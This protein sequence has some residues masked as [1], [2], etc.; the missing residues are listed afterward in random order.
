M[1]TQL[2]AAQPAE[3]QQGE[4]AR[5]Q[6]GAGGGMEA[7]PQQQQQQQ[8]QQQRYSLFCKSPNNESGLLVG[9]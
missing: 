6:V 9:L 8:Q 3:G 5:Q 1:G 4:E 7:E 2:G